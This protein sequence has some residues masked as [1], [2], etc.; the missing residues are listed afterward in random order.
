MDSLLTSL[1]LWWWKWLLNPQ[2]RSKAQASKNYGDGSDTWSRKSM[3]RRREETR[4]EG[5]LLLLSPRKS[6]RAVVRS[7]ILM[8]WFQLTQESKTWKGK[9]IRHLLNPL[10]GFEDR[11]WRHQA[12]AFLPLANMKTN[13]N[14]QSASRTRKPHSLTNLQESNH[15]LRPPMSSWKKMST[16]NT[17][18]V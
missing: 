7:N 13:R 15:H 2:S 16:W 8:A 11:A 17:S 5:L 18:L 14:P 4:K 3:S 9:W 12:M 10:L 6:Q 1:G